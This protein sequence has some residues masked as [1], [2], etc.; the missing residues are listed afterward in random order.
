MQQV[1]VRLQ[2]LAEEARQATQWA[3]EISRFKAEVQRLQDENAK[4]GGQVHQ[5]QTAHATTLDTL[6]KECQRLRTKK[7]KFEEHRSVIAQML[8]EAG[9]LTFP[10]PEAAL[11]S[12][13]LDSSSASQGNAAAAAAPARLTV[14]HLDAEIVVALRQALD[15][16]KAAALQQLRG[17]CFFFFSF[18]RLLATRASLTHQSTAPIRHTV[19]RNRTRRCIFASRAKSMLRLLLLL[20]LCISPQRSAHSLIHSSDTNAG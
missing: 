17:S 1:Q 6:N 12:Q 10:Q 5:L 16:T 14:K 7:S 9:F 11:T 20:L 19:P 4:L 3:Q 18:F 13:D 8:H 15:A 2:G